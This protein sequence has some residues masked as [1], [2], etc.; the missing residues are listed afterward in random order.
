ME[1]KIKE[2]LAK[3]AKDFAAQEDNEF[4]SSLIMDLLSN[5]VTEDH[6]DELV[7]LLEFLECLGMEEHTGDWDPYIVIEYKDDTPDY[8][9]ATGYWHIAKKTSL[10]IILEDEHAEVI[11]AR[12]AI[13]RIKI[14]R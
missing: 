10:S 5:G 11:I 3:I 13:K 4:V 6:I 8:E 9:T 12:N 1:I 2:N 7:L 14:C